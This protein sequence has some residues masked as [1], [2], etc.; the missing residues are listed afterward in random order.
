MTER[1]RGRVRA[2]EMKCLRIIYGVSIMDRIKSQEIRKKLRGVCKSAAA[3]IVR[4][5]TED[6]RR[7][8][9]KADMVDDDGRE[10]KH[11]S[12]GLRR[13]WRPVTS[14]RV[15]QRN[16]PKTGGDGKIF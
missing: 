11:G 9:D 3:W 16:W 12:K 8:P 1:L 15:T 2:I 14:E 5:P 4:P 7:D 10:E 6:E 13:Y